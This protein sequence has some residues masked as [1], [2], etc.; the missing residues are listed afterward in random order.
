MIGAMLRKLDNPKRLIRQ[1]ERYV[2]AAT[3]QMFRGRRP[4]TNGR[5]GVKWKKLEPATIDEKIRLKKAGKL[6]TTSPRRPMVRSGR[7]RD[8]LRVLERSAKGFIYGT[9]IKSK[10]GFSYGGYHNANNFPW[11]F[12][13]KQD[14]AQ[15]AKMTKD[16]LQGK[17]KL[18][19]R[20]LKR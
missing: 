15:M 18:A 4:D 8:S 6:G 19:R 1:I 3:R 20:Y 7:L 11:L 5:R 9:R 2:H 17:L 13:T 12:L 16:F 10:K 14:V